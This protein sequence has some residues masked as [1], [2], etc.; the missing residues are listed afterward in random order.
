MPNGS[1]PHI[2]GDFPVPRPFPNAG[3]R[4]GNVTGVVIQQEWRYS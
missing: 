4:T 3:G 2:S 1:E